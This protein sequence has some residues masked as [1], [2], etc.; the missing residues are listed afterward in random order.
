MSQ[1][2][3]EKADY[4]AKI[5]VLTERLAKASQAQSENEILRGGI[6]DLE[7]K[8]ARLGDEVVE[9]NGRLARQVKEKED[10]KKVF[11]RKE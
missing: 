3:R 5:N 10:Y 8:N 9:L 2:N 6:K 11:K 1:F 7:E 4:E